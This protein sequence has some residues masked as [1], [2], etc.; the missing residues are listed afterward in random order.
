MKSEKK[1]A[2]SLKF[3]SFKKLFVYL[4]QMTILLLPNSKD[5][6][7][8][9]NIPSTSYKSIKTIGTGSFGTV[10]KA[11]DNFTGSI[12]AIKAVSKERLTEIVVDGKNGYLNREIQTMKELSLDSD[13][14]SNHLENEVNDEIT[15]KVKNESI[16]NNSEKTG[17]CQH[18][19]KLINF[20]Q[21]KTHVYF[22]M[23]YCK[24]RNVLNYLNQV[25]KIQEHLAAHIFHQIV[26]AIKYG[27][28]RNI[29]HR[30]IKPENI[31][32]SKFPNIQVSDFGFCAFHDPQHI[33]KAF[34]GST[35]YLAPEVI[36]K[37]DHDPKLA[38]VWSLGVLLYHM[39][40]GSLPW[41]GDTEKHVTQQ[42]LAGSYKAINNIVSNECRNL[43]SSMMQVNPHKRI[44]LEQ[45]L[46]SPWLENAENIPMTTCLPKL[47][48]ET[49]NEK[50]KKKSEHLNHSVTSFGQSVKVHKPK[51]IFPIKGQMR[52]RLSLVSSKTKVLF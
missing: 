4:F 27:H 28:D 3:S 48:K 52:Q 41:D 11:V 22:V 15:D 49:K 19:N 5:L 36:C 38:D 12:L 32:F 10:F 37:I 14:I 46:L 18:I 39:V 42:I 24:D 23:D 13:D 8:I 20:Y 43:I 6:Y 7:S 31:L 9:E 44:T 30:N 45:I 34:C 2:R 51:P 26:T 25:G 33:S 35:G 40:T 21:T 1:S 50:L 47:Q 17:D 29:P 16:S